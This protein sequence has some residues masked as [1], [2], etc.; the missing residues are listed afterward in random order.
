MY[1]INL[2]Y[3]FGKAELKWDLISSAQNNFQTAC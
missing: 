2:I 3:Y 1:G